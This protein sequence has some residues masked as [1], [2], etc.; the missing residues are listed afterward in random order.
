MMRERLRRRYVH[1]MPSTDR[2]PGAVAPR[3]AAPIIGNVEFCFEVFR[4]GTI[5][6]RIYNRRRTDVTPIQLTCWALQVHEN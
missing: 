6:L 1:P 2:Q 5:F 3:A 4:F